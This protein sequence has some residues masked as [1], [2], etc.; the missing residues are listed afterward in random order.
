MNTASQ[1]HEPVDIARSK[2]PEITLAF[3]IMKICATTLGETAGDLLSMTLKIGYAASSVLLVGL[4]LVTLGAQ[5]RSRAY[6]PLLYWTVILSTSTAGTTLSD[7]MDRTLGLGY[8][9]GSAILAGLLGAVLLY[10][11]LSRKSLSIAR[12]QG[13]RGELLY[14]GA[15]LV[16]NTLGTALGDFLADS[17][18]LGFAGGALLI[19]GIIA[20][21]AAAYYFTGL[22]RVA[23]F[24]MAFVLTRPLGATAGDLLTKPVSAGGLN[25]GT[26][27]ASLVLLAVLLATVGHASWQARRENLQSA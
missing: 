4:F 25:L 19:A 12:V 14:W 9:T 17:S 16:S 2:L 1:A 22:S 27:G 21:I 20:L 6:H 11:K 13:G 24:W 18:G 15:I 10:W 5:L 3:W 26:A 7:F 8:A 23:L